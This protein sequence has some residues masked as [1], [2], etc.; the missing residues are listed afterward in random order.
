MSRRSKVT[1]TDTPVDE[2]A[3]GDEQP[4]PETLDEAAPDRCPIC[5]LRLVTSTQRCPTDPDTHTPER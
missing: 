3:Q 5:G 2:T 1:A 4:S